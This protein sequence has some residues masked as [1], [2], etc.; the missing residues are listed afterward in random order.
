[1]TRVLTLRQVTEPGLQVCFFTEIMSEE[2]KNKKTKLKKLLSDLGSKDAATQL[3]AV[4]SLKI[5]GDESAIE[6][7]L[8]A[9][10]SSKS[11][12]LHREITDLFNTMKSTDAPEIIMRCLDDDDFVSVRTMLLSS[13]WN[14]GLDYS[15]YVAEL[16]ELAIESELTEVFEIETIL[17]N[18]ENIPPDEALSDA[19]VTLGN[20]LSEHK[21]ES[22]PKLDMLL[23]IGTIL[24]RLN[25][26]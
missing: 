20:Y 17:E 23:N 13:I 5:H 11:S 26:D 25:D 16:T 15:E 18:L 6:P 4:A 21:N 10:I 24:K 22:S 12:E 14:S 7:L 2:E 3:E 1:M 19:L 9:M 8:H